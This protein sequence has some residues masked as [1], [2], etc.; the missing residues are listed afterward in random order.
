MKNSSFYNTL[1]KIAFPIMIQYFITS[2]INLMDS[3]MIGKLGEESVAALGIANQYFFLFNII[4]MGIFSGC[5]V[6]ISQFWGKKDIVNI[7]KVL[8]ISLVLGLSVSI[9]FTFAARFFSVEIISIFNKDKMVMNLGKSYLSVVSISYIFIAVSLAFGIGSRGV[10]KAFLP[11]ICSSFALIVNI[12]F[13]YVLIFGK[14][15]MPAMGVRGAAVATLIARICEMTLILILIYKRKHV[16]NASVKEMLEFDSGFFKDTMK[17]AVPVVVNEICWGL[18]MVIYS[19]IYGNMGTKAIAAVQIC[20]TIQNM[21]FII[22]FAVSNAACVMVGNEVGKDDFEKAKDYSKKLIKICSILSL[23]MALALSLSSRSIL[24][25]YNVSHEVYDNALFMLL[26]TAFILPVRFMN[27]LLIVGILR[28]G[29]DTSYIL[30]I[31]LGTMWLIGVPL[32][33]IGAFFMKIPVYQVYFLVTLEEVVKCL[34]S[35]KRYKSQKWIK[36]LVGSINAA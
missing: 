7:R 27:V 22:L 11:M 34:I 36:N 5:N 13:N 16:L 8:G 24:S 21:F 9:I 12:F 3:F 14:F 6:L 4:V 25:I 2:S 28:G 26:I 19:V 17:V 15:N 30:K 33:L 10:Q 18:G 31:E 1:L 29:G 32:C 35:I 23:V 20:M